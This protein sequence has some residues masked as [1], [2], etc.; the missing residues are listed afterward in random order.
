MIFDFDDTLADSPRFEELAINYLKENTSVKTLVDISLKQIKK[1]KSD[2]KIENGRIYVE[3]PDI[4]IEVKG[5]WVRKK[6]RVYLVPPDKFYYLEE[7][8]PDRLTLLAERYKKAKNKAIVTARIKTVR[9]LLEKYLDKLGLEQ[10]NF[11]LFMY[12]TKE[13]SEFRVASWKAK[14]IVN[15]IKTTGFKK[16]EYYD[17]KSKIVNAV[18]KAVNEQLPEVDFKGH[19]VKA[20]EMTYLK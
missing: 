4:Q 8:F 7:S 13:E 6:K 10:P 9:G 16:C 17:D 20:P 2:V 3:D 14:T 12:P 18:V 5:N 11:G 19:K 15:L 1:N